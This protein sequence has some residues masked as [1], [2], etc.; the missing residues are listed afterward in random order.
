MPTRIVFNTVPSVIGKVE[1]EQA[2]IDGIGDRPGDYEVRIDEPQNTISWLI[3]IDNPTGRWNYEF[4]GPAEQDPDFI[5]NKVEDGLPRDIPTAV[6]VLCDNCTFSG[7]TALGM[8]GPGTM[9]FS[10]GERNDVFICQDPNCGRLYLKE[11]GYFTPQEDGSFTRLRNQPLCECG[12]GCVMYIEA[13]PER[14]SVRYR[15]PCCNTYKTEARP[16]PG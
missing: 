6:R 8:N 12:N 14:E 7:I 2:V 10:F 11:I 4:F 15:C 16:S 9:N 5:R 3:T 1:V 13:V